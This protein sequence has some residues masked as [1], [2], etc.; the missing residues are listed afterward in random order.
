MDRK[1]ED[2]IKTAQVR[3][4]ELIGVIYGNCEAKLGQRG[5]VRH[6]ICNVLQGVIS[7]DW[8]YESLFSLGKLEQLNSYLLDAISKK[9]LLPTSVVPDY[10]AIKNGFNLNYELIVSDTEVPIYKPK[11]IFYQLAQDMASSL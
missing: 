2:T 6:V 9:I 4:L 3:I 11:S 5:S 10:L 1:D 8:K 7:V